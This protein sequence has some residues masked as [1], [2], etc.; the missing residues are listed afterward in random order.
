MHKVLLYALRK[1]YKAS[2]LEQNMDDI[3]IRALHNF[4]EHW[5]KNEIPKRLKETTKRNIFYKIN[6]YTRDRQI[7]SITGL[8]RTGKTTILYQLIEDLIKNEKINPKNILYFSF[9]EITAKNPEIIDEIIRYYHAAIIQKNLPDKEKRF[10]F[11][12][13]VQKIDNWQAILKRY[14]DLKYNIKFI[15]SGSESLFIRKKAKESL[16]GRNF[17]FQTNPLSFKEFIKFKRIN[18]DKNTYKEVYG[19][20]I[21]KQEIIKNLYKEYLMGGGFPETIDYDI[22]KKQEYIKNSILEKII[23]SDI[24]SMFK[25]TNPEILAKIMEIAS[26]N[27]SGLFE[28]NNIIESL[29]IGRNTAA[30][31]L[32]YLENSFLIKLS[33]NYTKSKIKQLR[34]SKKIYVTDTGIVNATLKKKTVDSPEE[35]G[36]LVE[37][38]IFNEVSEKNQV[39]FWRDKKQNEIDIIVK[40][41]EIMPIEVKYRNEI[42]GRDI[43]TLNNFAKKNN[44]KKSTVITKNLFKLDKKIDYIPAWLFSLI[45][46]EYE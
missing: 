29:N 46:E 33:Y 25:I 38:Q 1:V 34:T 15:V 44:I 13:E 23:F 19:E 12:D 26:N 42:R 7:I 2:I 41:K 3:T 35:W 4:N 43:K 20:S 24:P 36:K 27:T 30:L 22:E 16:A 21:T 32:S 17:E 14:Y 11:L 10:F 6:K 39:F 9:D 37:T 31:Y 40:N 28:I 5:E 8:R 18:I 45:E